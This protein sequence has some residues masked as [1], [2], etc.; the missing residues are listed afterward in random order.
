VARIDDLHWDD[1]RFFL[2][3][4][5]AGTLAGAARVMGVEHTT[6]GRRLSALERSLG[7]A[8]VL[9]GPEGL[10]PTPLGAR[11]LPLAEQVEQA[12][13]ATL[14]AARS[15]TARVRLSVPSGF[16]RL[17]AEEMHTLRAQH[18][19]LTLELVSGA[20]QVDLMKGEADLALR[21]AAVRSTELVARKLATLGWSLYASQLYLARRPFT[22]V[23]ELHN[24]ELIGFD[25]SLENVAGARWLRERAGS[26]P[27]VLRSREMTDMLAAASSGVGLAVLPCVLADAESALERLTPEVLATQGIALVYRSEARLSH[28]VRAVIEFVL[29]VMQR[30]RA[31]IAGQRSPQDTQVPT[32]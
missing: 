18:P 26:A 30:H 15:Q 13:L 28:E 20:Q 9:R 22:G 8:L 3:A 5:Q 16:T 25:D 23:A 24:H 27:I 32:T 17:F 2:R 12:V 21:T 6:V 29:G 19:Q 4:V 7:G 1:L 31:A 10:V 11:L 14:D